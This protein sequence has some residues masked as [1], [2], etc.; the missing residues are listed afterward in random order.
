MKIKATLV[1]F[2]RFLGVFWEFF[3][4]ALRLLISRYS[5]KLE[6]LNF[7]RSWIKHIKI[8]NQILGLFETIVFEKYL[9]FEKNDFD[10]FKGWFFERIFETRGNFKNLFISREKT[11]KNL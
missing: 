5:I 8:F 3:S 6:S 4:D 1:K 7:Y 9:L 10:L 11:V 2:H